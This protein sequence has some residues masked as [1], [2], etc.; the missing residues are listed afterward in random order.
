MSAHLETLSSLTKNQDHFIREFHAYEPLLTDVKREYE[1]TI[2]NLRDQLNQF[3]ITKTKLS[4]MEYKMAKEIQ[5]TIDTNKHIIESMRFF[6]PCLSFLIPCLYTS[7]DYSSKI[8]K[9]PL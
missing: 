5:Q 2:E 7:L 9:I 8:L 4:V 3:G 1:L 6:N